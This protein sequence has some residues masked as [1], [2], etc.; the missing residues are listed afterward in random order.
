MHGVSSFG[1]VR[2]NSS[3]HACPEG[4]WGSRDIGHSFSIAAQDTGCQF[5]TLVTLALGMEP[6]YPLSRRLNGP[7][8]CC[9]HF[10]ADEV[11]CAC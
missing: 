4:M 7:Q 8:S 1:T 5:Y 6:Q 10:G 3:S 11:W 9:G 2:I